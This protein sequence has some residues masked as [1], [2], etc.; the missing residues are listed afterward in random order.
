MIVDNGCRHTSYAGRGRLPACSVSHTNKRCTYRES[1]KS[2]KSI[3]GLFCLLG[4]A[5]EFWLTDVSENVC[6][7]W[8]KKANW[9]LLRSC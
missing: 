7:L 8:C 6:P 1:S 5:P 9:L 2:G 3:I 4:M